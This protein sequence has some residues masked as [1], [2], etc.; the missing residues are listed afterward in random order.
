VADHTPDTGPL[1]GR[2]ADTA[3]GAAPVPGASSTLFRVRS[4]AAVDA[5]A[6]ARAGLP[7]ALHDHPRYLVLERLGSGGMGTVFRAEHRMMGREVALK[8][9]SPHLVD[10]PTMV[11]RFRREIR[12]AARLSHPNIVTAYD[13]D[14]ADSTHFLVMEYIRG[15]DLE[16]VLR[17]RGRLAVPHACDYARQAALG[18]QYA[19]ECGMMHRDIKPHNLML[20]PCGRVKILD[21]G[22]ARHVSEAAA[23]AAAPPDPTGGGPGSRTALLNGATYAYAGAGTADYIAPEEAVDARRS[24]IRSDI[25]SLGCTLYRFLAGTVPFP[26]GGLKDKIRDHI[27]RPPP[28]LAALR[29]E[30]PGRLAA[31]V[32]R[33]MA[34]A[35]A[36]RHPTPAEVAGALAPFAVSRPQP[37]LIVDDEPATRQAMALA[38]EAEGYRVTEAANGREAL[39]ALRCE[40][41]P[42]LILLDLMMPVMDGWQFLRERMADPALAAIPVIVVSAASDDEARSVARGAA[43]YLHK[44]VTMDQL[45]ATVRE[46]ADGDVGEARPRQPEV[47]DP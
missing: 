4:G 15:T 27:E 34:K 46:S 38:L 13:A 6:A 23:A 45:R 22:L 32:R 3:P 25:Y 33:M 20:T 41:R 16:E 47:P 35:P 1:N 19:F 9:V 37:V 17:G 14:Q 42:C 36:D 2:P 29:P 11:E 26:G 8:I 30:V 5:A 10:R 40:P 44:P 21:F 18:L 31:V 12:A 39:D 24:D 28:E 43:H 7:P